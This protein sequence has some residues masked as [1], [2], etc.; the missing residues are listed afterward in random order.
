MGAARKAK[1]QRFWV[2]ALLKSKFGKPFEFRTIV[3]VIARI[4]PRALD[5]DNLAGSAKHVR[6]GIADWL[7]VNDGD[8]RIT[9]LYEQ[10]KDGKKYGVKMYFY[11]CE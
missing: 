1:D 9:W 5:G 3:I 11:C 6:D 10:S 7:G 4:G 8:N 2:N